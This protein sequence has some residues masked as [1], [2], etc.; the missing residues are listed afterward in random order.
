MLINYRKQYIVYIMPDNCINYVLTV[1]SH[2][3]TFCYISFKKVVKE[4]NL[5]PQMNQEYHIYRALLATIQQSL[6]ERDQHPDDELIRLVREFIRIGRRLQI[7][8]PKTTK[9]AGI[10]TSGL[11]FMKMHTFFKFSYT[12]QT[13][14]EECSIIG[15][16]I[17]ES[18]KTTPMAL[19]LKLKAVISC[20]I[21]LKAFLAKT[22]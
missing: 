5:N 12:N 14:L 7:V 15:D 22:L 10:D 3:L 16:F 9:I 20:K 6:K 21:S 2:R 18:K 8:K 17:K 11:M 4:K 13:M 19:I 1:S